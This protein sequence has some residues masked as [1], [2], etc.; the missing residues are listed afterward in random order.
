[1][2]NY[3]K[4]KAHWIFFGKIG[5]QGGLQKIGQLSKKIKYR[6]EICRITRK[7]QRNS[8]KYFGFFFEGDQLVVLKTK[9]NF[10]FSKMKF[11]DYYM[12]FVSFRSQIGLLLRIISEK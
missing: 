12:I 3:L 10:P 7:F 1:M 6:V 4:K 2:T 11:F 9:Q 8:I 5:Y